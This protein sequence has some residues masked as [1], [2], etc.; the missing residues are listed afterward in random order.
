MERIHP[1]LYTYWGDIG[2]LDQRIVESADIAL[3]IWMSRERVFHKMT[4]A[5]QEQI[6][7]WLGTGGWQRHLHR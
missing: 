1:I 3:A 4:A 7:A 5:E 2:H 6:I